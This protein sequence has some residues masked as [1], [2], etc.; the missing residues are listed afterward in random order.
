MNN[1]CF[2]FYNSIPK[3][4][5]KRLES[6]VFKLEFTNEKI[7]EI[8]NLMKKPNTRIL[9]VNSIDELWKNEET[10]LSRQ[11][12]ELLRKGK[13]LQSRKNLYNLKVHSPPIICLEE[14]RVSFINGR[15]R[16]AN[17][18]DLGVEKMP[19]IIEDEEQEN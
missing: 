3:E 5:T 13:Y 9:D 1:E 14:N 16:F 12:E 19:F 6:E 17:L 8:L 7:N 4:D 2:N 15:H 18:R 10:Y 11:Y